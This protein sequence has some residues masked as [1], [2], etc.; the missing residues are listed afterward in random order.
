MRLR[1]AAGASYIPPFFRV[2]PYCLMEGMP[3][4]DALR[5]PLEGQG[6]VYQYAFRF[7]ALVSLLASV[8]LTLAVSFRNQVMITEAFARAMEARHRQMRVGPASTWGGEV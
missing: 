6:Y 1:E 3:L 8:W 7:A 2:D 5:G 4:P